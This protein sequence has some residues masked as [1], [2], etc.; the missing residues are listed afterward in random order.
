M[1]GQTVATAI[2]AMKQPVCAQPA[3]KAACV[4]DQAGN[5]GQAGMAT[6]FEC[7][8][9]AIAASVFQAGEA[10][11]GKTVPSGIVLR[12]ESADG[13]SLSG[14]QEAGINALLMGADPFVPVP[15]AVSEADARDTESVSADDGV[16]FSRA[17]R[18][19][20]SAGGF[21]T[22][23]KEQVSKSK[24]SGE[25]TVRQQAAAEKNA[26]SFQP[27]LAAVGAESAIQ[28]S[29]QVGIPEKDIVRT[30]SEGMNGVSF[31]SL[32]SGGLAAQPGIGVTGDDLSA[33]GPAGELAV[34]PLAAGNPAQDRAV[35]NLKAVRVS[36]HAGSRTA[37]TE[38]PA[39]VQ[40]VDAH[41]SRTVTADKAGVSEL[42][43]Q[44]ADIPETATVKELARDIVMEFTEGNNEMKL[45]LKPE[46]LGNITVEVKADSDALTMVMRTENAHAKQLL[47]S[48]VEALKEALSQHGLMI[49]GFTVDVGED[50]AESSGRRQETLSGG[51]SGEREFHD[52]NGGESK[53]GASQPVFTQVNGFTRVNAWA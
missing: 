31:E 22:A 19:K 42:L 30:K 39:A 8:L 45:R 41:G 33:L 16:V 24:P 35:D 3:A 27:M 38:L 53:E 26:G 40:P 6:E 4:A 13:K 43:F 12:D 9:A 10:I 14:A 32:F 2:T 36:E 23:G 5:T 15:A 21:F 7:I 17:A 20:L 29:G 50:G 28:A 37:D 52:A 51:L 25:G 1:N 47:E 44:G 48:N 46:Y 18:V 34:R 11:S 49:D